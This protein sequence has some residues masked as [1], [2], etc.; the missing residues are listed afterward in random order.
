M[1]RFVV[2]ALALI[3]L[4][5]YSPLA[6][7]QRGG[8][9]GGG[10]FSPRSLPLSPGIFPGS[11]I[12]PGTQFLP[13][14]TPRF[15]PNRGFAGGGTTQ[16]ARPNVGFGRTG[17]RFSQTN[18]LGFGYG[19]GYGGYGDGYGY[20]GY[21]YGDDGYGYSYG[22][23]DPMFYPQGEWFE[24]QIVLGN[25]FPATLTIQL[26]SGDTPKEYSLTSP[27]LRPDQRYTF[28][29]NVRWVRG[30]KTYEA[31]RNVT[32]GSRDRGRLLIVS[33]DEVKE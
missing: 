15:V 27:V 2:P 29:V 20:N 4:V 14:P 23:Y 11:P 6:Q 32:L 10:G 31:K 7:A 28:A 1:F 16:Y 22:G 24:P 19:Y 25:E 17:S 3:A 8:H 9:G 13:Q 18:R 33:G 21:G 5:T 12:G 30:G 26:P